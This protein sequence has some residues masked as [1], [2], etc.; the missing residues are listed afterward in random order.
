M[1]TIFVHTHTVTDRGAEGVT[2]RGENFSFLALWCFFRLFLT[3]RVHPPDLIRMAP[4]RRAQSA[5]ASCT[6]LR[7]RPKNNNNTN[8][9]KSRLARSTFRGRIQSVGRTTECTRHTRR[10]K[11]LQIAGQSTRG[12]EPA[13]WHFYLEKTHWVPA[14][15]LSYKPVSSL[16]NR[17]TRSV[18][19][20]LYSSWGCFS[21][22]YCR[23]YPKS[24]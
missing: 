22:F 20:P 13:T 4:P 17:G 11:T 16:Y 15:M 9:K 2:D 1:R 7:L 23:S 3:I 12:R 21:S 10:L 8:H 6:R 18:H 24:I 5:N 14:I 19:P